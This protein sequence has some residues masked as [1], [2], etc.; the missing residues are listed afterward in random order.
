MVFNSKTI[1]R[2]A[3]KFAHYKVVDKVYD[4]RQARVLYGD[5]DSPQ[6][7]LAKDGDPELLFNY[8]QR[9]LEIAESIKPASI[10]IIGGGAF[11]LPTAILERLP[12]TTI[13]VVEVDDILPEIA[14]EYFDLP[15]D[16]PR[17]NIYISD[18][19]VY[20]ESAK[21]KY[22]LIILDA[23]SD[24]TIPTSLISLEAA[25]YYRTL[26]NDEGAMA[27][28]FIAAYHPHEHSLTYQLQAVF[29]STFSHIEVYPAD[30]YNR[31]PY[32][33]NLVLIA[34]KETGSL[35]LEYLQGEE[36]EL[37][38]ISSEYIIRD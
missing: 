22:D 30:P 31:T 10:L 15:V 37:Q 29:G 19:R 16:D 6:S 36:I 34:S 13:D 28:N 2:Q 25:G 1:F 11:T 23:F 9:F 8:N 18:G 5:H 33:Q 12:D 17:L 26:L 7:G 3:S 35:R 32:E 4:G 24:Y 27:I 38:G 20:I 21:K 14:R